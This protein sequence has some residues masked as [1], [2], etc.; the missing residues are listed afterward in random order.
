MK[1]INTF[2]CKKRHIFMSKAEKLS[3]LAELYEEMDK[4][5]ADSC[6]MENHTDTDDLGASLKNAGGLGLTWGD[7]YKV[8]E[9][10]VE[11][12]KRN[13]VSNLEKNALKIDLRKED[14]GT[15][16]CLVHHGRH[17]DLTS[18]TTLEDAYSILMGLETKSINAEQIIRKFP[19]DKVIGEDDLPKAQNY[20][21]NNLRY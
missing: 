12:G 15:G 11:D 17:V 8:H 19:G 13:R 7:F 21:D 5:F 1:N 10:L 6:F 4:A 9:A 2:I 20:F 18:T 3:A 14:G 16:M